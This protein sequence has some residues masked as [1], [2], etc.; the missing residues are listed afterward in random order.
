MNTTKD[1]LENLLPQ[2]LKVK[3]SSDLVHLLPLKIGQMPAMLKAI[4]PLSKKLH[5]DEVDWFGLLAEHGDALLDA[6]AIGANK[7]RPWIDGLAADDALLLAAKIIE[8][9][10]D[11]FAQRV[12]PR[13]ETLFQD[14][15]GLI[16]QLGRT[17]RAGS[18]LS[19]S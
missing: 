2:P 19:N 8:V 3:L 13:V 9:N 1:D 10:A 14:P 5:G 17:E 15:K 6:V 11:F 7:P 18:T 4:A 16:A 12:L